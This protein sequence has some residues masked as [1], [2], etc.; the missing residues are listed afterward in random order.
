MRCLPAGDNAG[1]TKAISHTITSPGR[2]GENSWVCL[3]WS[4]FLYGFTL[5]LSSFLIFG[6][7]YQHHILVFL[8]SVSYISILYT[9]FLIFG[10]Y[11]LAS[12]ISIVVYRD[13]FNF[14]I[15]VLVS[16]HNI[17]TQH[18]V[19]YLSLPPLT[20]P[21]PSPRYHYKTGMLI[22]VPERKLV[23]KFGDAVFQHRRRGAN[24]PLPYTPD[25]P[26]PTETPTGKHSTWRNTR[27][28]VR[29]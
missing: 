12:V 18:T 24:T 3:K 26:S 10:I 22:S 16:V 14:V 8:F 28:P 7:L 29:L 9:S 1:P 4:R 11:I 5:V 2:W 20:P 19:F 21:P 15:S 23:Y 6:L 17:L 13:Q 25:S 27:M